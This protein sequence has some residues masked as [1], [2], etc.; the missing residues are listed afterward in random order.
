MTW[1]TAS[2]VD[3][4]HDLPKSHVSIQVS[5]FVR[6]CAFAGV[7]FGAYNAWDMKARLLACGTVVALLACGVHGGKENSG[8]GTAQDAI[9][10]GSNTSSYP[11]AVGINI[12]NQAV[13]SGALIAKNLVMTARHCVSTINTGESI[14]PT[15]VF[16]GN[17]APGSFGVTTNPT[18][19]N[20]NYRGVSQVLVP[21]STKVI[22]NDIALLVLSSNVPAGE[23]TPIT[24]VVQHAA[25]NF[26]RYAGTFTAIGYG[27]TAPGAND[28]GQRR[29][30]QD[31]PLLCI[32][33]SQSP[34]SCA[35]IV[36]NN[37]NRLVAASEFL[38]GPGVCQGDSGS[39]AYPQKNFNAAGT[40]FS[41][42]VLSRGPEGSCDNG[43]YTRTDSHKAFLIAGAQT[44][45]SAGGYTAPSWTQ[46]EAQDAEDTPYTGP[47][48]KDAG[49]DTGKSDAGTGSAFGE[50]C[51]ADE[52]CASGLCRTIGDGMSCSQA[53]ADDNPCPD[54]YTCTDSVCGKPAATS[55]S[56]S[57]PTN[58]AQTTTT[59]TSG[60]ALDPTKPTPWRGS[61]VFGLLAM[62]VFVR[63]GRKSK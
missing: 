3:E 6:F 16:N 4:P 41:Y 60:C 43:I 1:G 2:Y 45:A 55:S 51:E 53:C 47:A 37:N 46:A 17:Y 33:G 32:D 23:A 50:T 14:T 21:S 54:G 38:T 24:P 42:G 40:I 13:C 36:D 59:T 7:R 52:D 5:A 57:T 25:F 31:I 49:K 62:S 29:I 35:G 61:V 15:S 22:G 63:R 30:R 20:V 28:S 18:M 27:L 9:Q 12:G 58:G 56:G 26:V 39:S 11:F 48:P 44:A 10:G 19:G 8:T 34:G